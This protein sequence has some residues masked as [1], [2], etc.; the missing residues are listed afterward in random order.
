MTADKDSIRHLQSVPRTE[1][2]KIVNKPKFKLTDSEIEACSMEPAILRSL[3]DTHENI[4]E[5]AETLGDDVRADYHIT[6]ASELN[7]QADAEE[8]ER[9]DLGDYVS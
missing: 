4:A 7:E 9:Q 8:R 3:A 1:G 5:R 6:R 2:N